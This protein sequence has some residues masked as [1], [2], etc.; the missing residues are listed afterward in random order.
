M[1]AK[2]ALKTVVAIVLVA[3]SAG[4]AVVAAAFAVFALLRDYVGPS[5]AAAIVTGAVALFGL[6]VGL[7]MFRKANPPPAAHEQSLAE[8]ALD[9]AKERPLAAAGLAA[10]AGLVVLRNP[11]L[12][13]AAVTAFMAGKASDKT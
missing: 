6:I 1:I 13:T 4:V 11:K 10:V 8:R 7:T 12:V 2:K 9:L 5:G 3:T